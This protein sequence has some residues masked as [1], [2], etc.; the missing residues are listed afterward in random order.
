[1]ENKIKICD[2]IFIA[3]LIMIVIISSILIFAINSNEIG[4]D[5]KVYIEVNGS[6]HSV[7]PLSEDTEIN[8]ENVGT[9]IIEDS[10]VRIE[11]A[12]CNDK[13][14]E[15]MGEISQSYQSIICLPNRTIIKIISNSEEFD[16][17]AG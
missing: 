11:N 7:V 4:N 15:H 5:A 6:Q 16:D 12:L 3:I 8:I 13:V 9:V 10:K 2:L 14:C 17:I 1:M